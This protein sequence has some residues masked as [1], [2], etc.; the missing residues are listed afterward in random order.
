MSN[1]RKYI[2]QIY[3]NVMFLP[4]FNNVP[5]VLHVIHLL[6]TT[7]HYVSWHQLSNCSRNCTIYCHHNIQS[8]DIVLQVNNITVHLYSHKLK[9]HNLYLLSQRSRADVWGSVGVIHYTL[10]NRLHC[11]FSWIVYIAVNIF[12]AFYHCNKN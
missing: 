11:W 6:T 8:D 4:S 12:K 2:L 1:S 7:T 10:E 5:S 3:R 9:P